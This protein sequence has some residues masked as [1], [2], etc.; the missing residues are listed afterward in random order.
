VSLSNTYESGISGAV[1]AGFASLSFVNLQPGWY[2]VF[3]GG[4]C[5]NCDNSRFNLSLVATAPV[6]EPETWAML[7]AGLG[8]VGA[9]VRRR[10]A[11]V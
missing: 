10:S 9:A 5:G 2:T 8:L 3:V 6:P 4:A 7:L 1:G 11:R